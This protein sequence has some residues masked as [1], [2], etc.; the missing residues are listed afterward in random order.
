[1][2]PVQR[3]ALFAIVFLVSGSLLGGALGGRLRADAQRSEAISE[4]GPVLAIVESEYVGE[5]EPSQLI[6]GAIEGMLRTLDPHSNYFDPTAFA[7]MRDEQRGRFHGL[8][9]QITK[10]GPD[11]PLT[12]IAPIDDTPAARAGLQSGDIIAQIEGRPTM[13]MTVQDA[14]RL[15]KGEKGTRVTI[16]ITRPG[17]D[18][19][20]DV[21]LERDEIPIDSVR[22]AYMLQDGV[23]VVRIANFTNNTADELDAA[24]RQLRDEGMNRLIVDLRGNPGGLLEQA[25]Q[26]SER[27]L[28]PGKLIVYTRGR[29]P[30]SN[31]DFVAKSGTAPLEMPL[32]VLVDRSSA[33]A[34]EIVSGAIQDH[35]RG[36]VVGE[37]TF[38]KGLVQRVF[39]LRD[40]AGVAVTTAKYYTPA[41]RLI[42]RDYSDVDDYYMRRFESGETP[43][44]ETTDDHPAEVE[45]P[46]DQREV[47][48]TAS[49]RKVYGGGGITP[50]ALVR[51]PRM[52]P[53]MF[54]LI[55]DNVIFD[56]AVKFLAGH[57]DVQR[58]APLPDGT[59]AEF[60]QFAAKRDAEFAEAEFDLQREEI[61]LRL[62]AQIARIRWGQAEEARIIGQSDPQMRRAL[63][64][65]VEAA[66]LVARVRSAAAEPTVR[67][68]VVTPNSPAP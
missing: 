6:D 15:L 35:D 38:G 8:G 1:M 2:S 21:T 62:R 13:D 37:T 14:V 10:R 16:T 9:I 61:A 50:D 23:G 42:Q 64:L 29:I 60:R 56:F 48:R 46:L 34:S 58:G 36:L 43:E 7:E 3:P 5:V 49:G 44:A 63:E 41:G 25:V 20:F 24:L 4:L 22:V 40:G 51:A 19:D 52:T 32:V 65:F 67:A 39:P 31:Q 30:G 18:R 66:Q 33:S 57:P 47:F 26:V 28:P 54:R 68:A 11:K 12:I 55:R 53:L 17:I 59:F 45:T 27:F